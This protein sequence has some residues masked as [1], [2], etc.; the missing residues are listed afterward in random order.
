MSAED[1]IELSISRHIAAP[2]A[3]VWKVMTERMEEWWCPEPWRMEIIAWDFRP[4]GRSAMV[5]KGP[6]GEE[7]PSEGIFLEVS[8][9]RRF[10]S[11]D[12]ITADL[13]PQEPFMIGFWEIEPEDGGTRYTGRARHWT[14]DGKKRHEEMG[15]A[16]GWTKVADQLAALCE[17]M[18]ATA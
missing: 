3:T 18:T 17:E 10:V 16:D 11:T 5:M 6:E 15:F 1:L 9:G 12:A 7:F 14:E 2:P 4:G 13:L 8:P